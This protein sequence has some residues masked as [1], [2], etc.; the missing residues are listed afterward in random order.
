M[1]QQENREEKNVNSTALSDFPFL[2][3]TWKSLA[4]IIS[5]FRRAAGEFYRTGGYDELD[6][7]LECYACRLTATQFIRLFSETFTVIKVPYVLDFCDAGVKAD[8]FKCV[9][10]FRRHSLAVAYDRAAERELDEA[11]WEANGHRAWINV[12]NW[13]KQEE[14]FDELPLLRSEAEK[15]AA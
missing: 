12:C 2:P 1:W 4:E 15:M 13:W 7:L 8:L 3:G 11:Q 10:R 14:S 9:D 6:E 5:E